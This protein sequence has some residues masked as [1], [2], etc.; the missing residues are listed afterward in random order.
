MFLNK[1]CVFHAIRYQAK[2]VEEDMNYL[3]LFTQIY[4]STLDIQ[5]TK[6][7][8]FGFQ[9]TYI[10]ELQEQGALTKNEC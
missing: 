1:Y 7:E 6:I 2:I 5:Q 9:T 10:L 3:N 4:Y 8:I